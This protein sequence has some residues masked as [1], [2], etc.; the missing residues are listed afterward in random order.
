MPYTIY[1]DPQVNCVFVRLTGTFSYRALEKSTSDTLKHPDYRKGM[2]ILRDIRADS[3]TD[4]WSFRGINKD[5][6][7]Q[8]SRFDRMLGKCKWAV[9]V[10]DAKS[11]AK[12]HQFIATGRLEN[13]L[14]KRKPFRELD[15]ALD[16]L[17]VPAGYELPYPDSE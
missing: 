9:V 13:N 17:G 8:M 3:M 5:G 4:D 2:N 1:V 6:K 14:V 15:K 12:V 7:A 10:A 16:W 11:Y